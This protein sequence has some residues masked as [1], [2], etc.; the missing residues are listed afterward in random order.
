MLGT[1]YIYTSMNRRD[2]HSCSHGALILVGRSRQRT[3]KL[4]NYI[5]CEVK[6]WGRWM[7]Q[8][9]GD[10]EGQGWG[11]SGLGKGGKVGLSEKGHMS[12][13][14]KAGRKG[15]M[16]LSGGKAVMQGFDSPSNQLNSKSKAPPTP[17]PFLSPSFP[18]TYTN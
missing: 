7:E 4:V 1:G 13:E 5:G 17:A 10:Q 6:F 11:R 9:V 12:K 16:G 3:N 8:G 14:L 15:V 2:K 18:F